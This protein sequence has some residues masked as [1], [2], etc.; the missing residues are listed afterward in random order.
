MANLSEE[1]LSRRQA[2]KYL[3]VG[4]TTIAATA[5]AKKGV[6]HHKTPATQRL[7]MVVDLRKCNGCHTCSVA[8]KAEFEVPLGAFRSW[9][10]IGEEGK[11]P[12]VKRMITPKL[13]NHCDKPPCINV[14]PVKATYARSD[15]TIVID[16]NICIGCKACISACPYNTRFFNE[17]KR[18]ADK[19]DFC[20]HRYENGVV[21]SCV[22]GCPVSAR[23][24]GNLGDVNGEVAKLVSKH[25]VQVL[26]PELGTKPQVFYILP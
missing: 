8:C 4:A 2:L 3:G 16:E 14:C 13:C 25:Q 24:F 6:A 11:Y 10:E 19:C 12:M 20:L 23:T 1:K 22:N 18:T 21:P 7:A 9:V 5:I 17:V 15:G 26:R